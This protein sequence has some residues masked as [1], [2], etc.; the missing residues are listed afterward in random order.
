[1]GTG[2]ISCNKYEERDE[3]ANRRNEM[4]N[5]FICHST[6]AKTLNMGLRI[7]YTKKTTPLIGV[8]F[9]H[10]TTLDV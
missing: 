8:V 1:M 9:I 5:K 6:L 10:D 4:T 7:K 2:N 3:K